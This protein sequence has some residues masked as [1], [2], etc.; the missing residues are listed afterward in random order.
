MRATRGGTLLAMLALGG[1]GYASAP[2]E[3]APA[4][5]FDC[6]ALT[7]DWALAGSADLA[8]LAPRAEAPEGAP[9]ATV[10]IE[11]DAGGRLRMVLRRRVGDVLREAAALR[12]QRPDDYRV[13]RARTLGEPAPELPAYY[14]VED[15]GPAGDIVLSPLLDRCEG[16][17][18][19]AG[20]VG[21][22]GPSDDDPPVDQTYTLALAL[23]AR[24]DLLVQRRIS[25]EHDAGFSFFDQRVTYYTYSHSDWHRFTAESPVAARA[26][27]TAADLPPV[28]SPMRRL[29]LDLARRK[30]INDVPLWFRDHVPAGNEITLF[31]E[32]FVPV[33]ARTPDEVRFEVA[34]RF[35][36]EI[37]EPFT[38]VLRRHAQIR[39]IRVLELTDAP[40]D[41]RNARIEFTF[42]L[43]PPSLR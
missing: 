25:K 10:S 6:G 38:P 36:R 35:R 2:N 24:G 26:T 14:A 11:D 4:A 3:Y 31:R 7:G 34:G 29:E 23:D 17:W 9:Y 19:V 20:E 42:V 33:A 28:P 41:R 32:A 22:A 13:W 8:L 27:V 39:D 30:A 5:D 43:D 15:T 21:N 40:D 12:R 37:D 1:C 18:R 16:G